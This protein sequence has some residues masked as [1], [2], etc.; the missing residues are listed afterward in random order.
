MALTRAIAEDVQ[1]FVRELREKGWNADAVVRAD[2]QVLSMTVVIDLLSMMVP[3]EAVEEEEPSVPGLDPGDRKYLLAVDLREVL[4]R[5]A[6]IDVDD[7]NTCPHWVLAG[8]L[9][10]A[11]MDQGDRARAVL[12]VKDA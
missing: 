8:E 1:P 11:A 10:Q 5:S 9:A 12:E 3:V 2:G 7:P 4:H 6:G